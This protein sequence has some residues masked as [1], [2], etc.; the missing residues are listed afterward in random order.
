MYSAEGDQLRPG[1]V[2]KYRDWFLPAITNSA[3]TL[4]EGGTP[5]LEAA[6]LSRRSGC[7]VYLK[8]ES[9]NPTGTFKDRGMAVAASGSLADGIKTLICVS[10]GSTAASAAAFAARAGLDCIVLTPAGLRVGHE[11]AHATMCGA[12]IFQVAGN[13]DDCRAL[14]RTIG[15]R[16]PV[17]C[18][19]SHN[20]NRVQGQKTAAFEVVDALGDA[21]DIHCMSSGNRANMTAY[22]LG[23]AEYQ[24]AGMSS[25]TPLVV[26][27]AA[28]S[29]SRPTVPGG[30]RLGQVTASETRQAAALLA[31]TEAVFAD[32][33]SA[34][35][36]AGLLQEC[37]RGRFAKGSRIVC[38]I[39]G[40]GFADTQAAEESGGEIIQVRGDAYEIA[41]AIGIS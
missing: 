5:L 4:A 29:A 17:T 25:R 11:M 10:A 16:F 32:S 14:V 13:F 2:A 21:P 38:T 39:S 35:A 33:P 23:Y 20:R 9:S 27:F 36:V 22:S 3:V 41:A 28:G 37:Q 26:G 30:H 1:V 31:G 19:N 12:R 40:S 6:N 15:S 7:R 18:V 24:K 34:A 8:I